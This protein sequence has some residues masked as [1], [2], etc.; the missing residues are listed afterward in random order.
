VFSQAKDNTESAVAPK[1]PQV[2][3]KDITDQVLAASPC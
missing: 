3:I 1:P 2:L